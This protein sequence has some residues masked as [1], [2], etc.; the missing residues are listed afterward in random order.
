MDVTPGADHS[1][2]NET[3][4]FPRVVRRPFSIGTLCHAVLHE[5]V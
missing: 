4:A 1:L 5:T 3:M 2:V